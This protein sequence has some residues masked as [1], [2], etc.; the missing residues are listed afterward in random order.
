MRYQFQL[1]QSNYVSGALFVVELG[2]YSDGS[3]GDS[4]RWD[5]GQ[6]GG[7][8]NRSSST[9]TGESSAVG[10]TGGNDLAA[11]IC[12]TSFIGAITDTVA[13]VNVLAQAGTIGAASAAQAR[14][15]IEDVVDAGLLWRRISYELAIVRAI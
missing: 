5:S 12:T 13:E 14:P 4:G 15:L 7:S 9:S 8:R 6:G 3:V 11:N 1:R 10:V 2:T